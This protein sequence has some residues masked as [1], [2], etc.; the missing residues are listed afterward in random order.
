MSQEN[1][2]IVRRVADAFMAGLEPRRLGTSAIEATVSVGLDARGA[3]AVHHLPERVVSTSYP[4]A[5][6]R[7]PT[8][9]VDSRA[10]LLELGE[11]LDLPE[12]LLRRRRVAASTVRP[13]AYA[14]CNGEHR[15]GRAPICR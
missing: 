9:T 2:E 15:C 1:G 3:D 13:R 4:N 5:E 14:P 11:V 7:S 6:P 12:L 10:G 8:I